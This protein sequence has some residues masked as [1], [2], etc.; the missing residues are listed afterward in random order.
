MLDNENND[1]KRTESL[2]VTE[3][4]WKHKSLEESE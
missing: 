1:H 3:Y 2:G 4:P